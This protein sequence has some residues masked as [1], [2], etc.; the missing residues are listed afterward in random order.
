M[1]RYLYTIAKRAASQTPKQKK[2]TNIEKQSAALV[3]L[4]ENGE[5]DTA[6]DFVANYGSIDDINVAYNV[7]QNVCNILEN[8]Y[9]DKYQVQGYKIGGTSGAVQSMWNLSQ[10]V[11]SPF[12]SLQRCRSNTTVE[13]TSKRSIG[14]ESEFVFR[15]GQTLNLDH[16]QGNELSLDEIY[17]LIASIHPGFEI[18]EPRIVYDHSD[19]SNQSVFKVPAPLLV[20]DLCWTGGVVIGP[21]NRLNDVGYA[22]WK[23]YDEQ[24]LRDLAVEL[25]VNNEQNVIGYARDVMQSSPFVALLSLYNYLLKQG[26]TIQE[27]QYVATGTVTGCTLLPRDT[28]CESVFENIGDVEVKLV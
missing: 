8:E 2:T 3:S 25:Y 19:A 23:A 16:V 12:Y 13:I 15:I 11:Y 5:T 22:S 17:P 10:P 24:E 21:E 14:V 6:D 18:I 28:V 9:N 4:I 26:Q 20:A 7:Q 27:G 1:R